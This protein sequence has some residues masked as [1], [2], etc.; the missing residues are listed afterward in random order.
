MDNVQQISSLSKLIPSNFI[1]VNERDNSQASRT[2]AIELSAMI[3]GSFFMILLLIS[4][5]QP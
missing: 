4:L 5:F 3:S 2:F 1:V